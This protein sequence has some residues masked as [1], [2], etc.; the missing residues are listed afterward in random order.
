MKRYFVLFSGEARMDIRRLF[1]Y[2]SN[3]CKQPLTA[4]RYVNRVNKTI[5]KLS[6]HAGSVAVCQSDFIQS[7]YGP[8]ARRV[9]YRKIAI[10]FVVSKNT[11]HIKRVMAA[12]LIY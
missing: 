3:T 10:I 5:Q 6:I 7:R 2:I 4:A 1:K 8:G 12:S 9:N 11:V